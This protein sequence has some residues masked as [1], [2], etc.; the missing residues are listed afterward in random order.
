MKLIRMAIAVPV[1]ALAGGCMAVPVNPGYY[2]GPPVYYS[3]PAPMYYAPPGFY[4][5]SLGIGIYGGRFGHGRGG[6]H[7]YRRR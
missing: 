3:A 6:G 5:P 1:L 4:G 2:A 7:G